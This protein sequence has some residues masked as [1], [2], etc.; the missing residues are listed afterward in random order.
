ML[1][2]VGPAEKALG[3]NVRVV[4]LHGAWVWTALVAFLLA[5][6]FGL[7]GL[8]TRRKALH[9]WSRAWGRTGLLFWITYL[10]LSMWAM[11]TNWNGLFLAEPRWRLGVVFALGGLILQTGLSLVDEPAWAS[12][13]NIAYLLVLGLALQKAP[14]VMHPSSPILQSGSIR[15]QV[16]FAGL[17]LL[18]LL[19]AWQIE[20]GWM[21]MGGSRLRKIAS[22]ETSQ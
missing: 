16:F 1:T 7:A 4:Y 6:L 5:A 19:S 12:A 8:A 9:F 18:C 14:E 2:A 3:A 13:G 11:Q 20:R 17:L 10:P 15:I 21:Q 22:S